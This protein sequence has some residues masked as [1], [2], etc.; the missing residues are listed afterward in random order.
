MSGFLFK[1]R[2]KPK[3]YDPE[4]QQPVLRKS[5]CTGETTAGFRD[6]KD[7]RFHEVMAIRSER[8]LQAFMEQYGVEEI[9]KTIY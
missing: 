4:T 1:K 3:R 8:D 5:I 9:P 7:G 2:S 6:R